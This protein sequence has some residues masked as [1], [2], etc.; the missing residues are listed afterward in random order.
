M[1]TLL[2]H[3]KNTVRRHG[4][5]LEFSPKELLPQGTTYA[6]SD[7]VDAGSFGSSRCYTDFLMKAPRPSQMAAASISRNGDVLAESPV[8]PIVSMVW[9]TKFSK[10]V[11]PF[12]KR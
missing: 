7:V 12:V 9:G 3:V 8:I 6:S 1:F 2:A 11:K 10:F 5:E 4:Y